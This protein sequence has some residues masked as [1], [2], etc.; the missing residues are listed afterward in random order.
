MRTAW[1]DFDEGTVLINQYPQTK[2]Y[3]D[4]GY[5]FRWTLQIG[6]VTKDLNKLNSVG[7]DYEDLPEYEKYVGRLIIKFTKGMTPE[8]RDNFRKEHGFERVGG[9]LT[10]LKQ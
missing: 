10:I 4:F 2:V 5:A 9:P 8:Q 3:Q 7:Y 6:T 1:C